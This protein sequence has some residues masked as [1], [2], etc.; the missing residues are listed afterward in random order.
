MSDKNKNIVRWGLYY[1]K[2]KYMKAIAQR[3]ELQ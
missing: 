3:T 2:F 1:I